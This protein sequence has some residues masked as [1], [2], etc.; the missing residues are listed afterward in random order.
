MNNIELNESSAEGGQPVG[1]GEALLAGL[2]G[3]NFQT[4]NIG[5]SWHRP[6]G[7]ACSGN[8]WS[9]RVLAHVKRGQDLRRRWYLARGMGV[10]RG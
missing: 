9:V 8:I 4:I 3:K 1:A 2:A 10:V 7:M 5:S 6:L